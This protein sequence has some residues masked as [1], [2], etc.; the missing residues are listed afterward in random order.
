MSLKRFALELFLDLN[1][2][3][4]RILYLILDL[5]LNLI[6]DLGLDLG[7][8]RILWFVAGILLGLEQE[9]GAV[10]EVEVEEVLRLC[11]CS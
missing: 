3:P 10:A 8:H 5:D 7:R 9:D 6:F 2:D 4:I 1:L 11:S